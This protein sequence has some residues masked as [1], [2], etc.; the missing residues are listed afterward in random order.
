MT[1]PAA[2]DENALRCSSCETIVPRLHSAPATVRSL[3]LGHEIRLGDLICDRCLLELQEE[4][5]EEE[6]LRGPA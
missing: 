3:S 6:I 2:P 5:E 4:R 1:T